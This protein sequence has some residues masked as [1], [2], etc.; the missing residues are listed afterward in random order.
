[1]QLITKV[2]ADAS[3]W[4]ALDTSIRGSN[5]FGDGATGG[6]AQVFDTTVNMIFVIAG[7]LAF[8]YLIYSGFVYLTSGGNPEGVKKGQQGIISAII[9]LVIIFMAYG[10]VFFVVNFLTDRA[11]NATPTTTPAAT[12]AT[13]APAATPAPTSPSWDCPP[14]EQCA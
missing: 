7:I 2:L 11:G 14:G 13:P 6:W 3:R 8:I 1:M 4:T 12:E 5:I 10:I 9:G